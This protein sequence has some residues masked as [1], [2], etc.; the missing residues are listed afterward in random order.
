MNVFEEP[1]WGTPQEAVEVCSSLVSTGPTPFLM[2]G[3]FTK[4]IQYHFSDTR[5]IINPKLHS[6]KWVPGNCNGSDGGIYIGPG[7]SSDEDSANANPAVFVRRSNVDIGA[8]SQKNITVQ[9]QS[10]VKSPHA[11]AGIV[12]QVTID[13]S[14][15]IICKA[16]SVAEADA[17]AEEVF[18]R[19]LN[20]MSVIRDD[21]RLGK[22]MPTQLSDV[23]EMANEAEKAFYAVVRLSWAYVYRWSLRQEAPKIKRMHLLYEDK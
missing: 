19:M 7:G 10:L 6:M 1:E 22:F 3:I 20:Y 14:H 12:H 2:T 16:K 23:K 13:G 4:L 21:F 5:N 15:S 11:H 9:G 18:T 17:L 8:I